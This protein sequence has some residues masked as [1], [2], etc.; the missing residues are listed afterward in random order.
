LKVF[1]Q[2]SLKSE[3]IRNLRL[4]LIPIFIT[5]AMKVYRG[6]PTLGYTFARLFNIKST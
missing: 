4:T 1:S 3:F 6:G 2:I 5:R